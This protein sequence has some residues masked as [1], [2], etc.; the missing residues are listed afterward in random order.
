M[1]EKSLK[2]KLK[3]KCKLSVLPFGSVTWGGEKYGLPLRFLAFLFCWDFLFHFAS[4][5][6]WSSGL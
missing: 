6:A 4:I 3:E 1:V 2:I 5:P